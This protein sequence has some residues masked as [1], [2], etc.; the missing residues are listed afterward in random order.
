MGDEAVNTIKFDSGSGKMVE[1]AQAETGKM[2]R[3]LAIIEEEDQLIKR[4]GDEKRE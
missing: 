1:S 2:K 4:K 3:Q